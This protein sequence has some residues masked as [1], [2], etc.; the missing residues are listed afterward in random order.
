[1]N[2]RLI[3]EIEHLRRVIEAT[4]INGKDGTKVNAVEFPDH[5]YIPKSAESVDIRNLASL[6]SAE[7]FEILRFQCPG[8]AK[9][10]FIGYALF[11]DALLFSEVEFIP[12]VNGQ[13]ILPYHGTPI[14]NNTQQGSYRMSLGLAAD[15]A[16][17]ALIQCV[18]GLNPGDV[19]TWT[20]INNA[21]VDVVMG[22]RM[23]GYLYSG[24]KRAG[25]RV[26]A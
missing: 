9:A 12:R 2:E 22:V 14:G 6:A 7:T 3:K 15:I 24:E 17:S 4:N 8:G 11:N 16:N 21:A 10:L 19:L 25:A 20:A 26:G 1:M 13:R 23:S 5:L 18:V